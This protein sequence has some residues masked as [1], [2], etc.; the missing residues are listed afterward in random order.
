MPKRTMHA[1]QSQCF[2]YQQ[3]GAVIVPS[4]FRE[5]A[6][7]IVMSRMSILKDEWMLYILVFGLVFC[8]YLMRDSASHTEHAFSQAL[9]IIMKILC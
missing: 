5:R 6:S 4:I 3:G 7:V 2:T 9:V 8:L 1:N